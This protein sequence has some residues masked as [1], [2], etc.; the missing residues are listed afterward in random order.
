[1]GYDQG[2]RNSPSW[3]RRGRVRWARGAVQHIWGLARHVDG[4][5]MV[6]PAVRESRIENEK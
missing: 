6:T 5:V 3:A 1:M 4:T 2:D